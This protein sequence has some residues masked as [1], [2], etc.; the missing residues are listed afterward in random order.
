[1]R[2]LSRFTIQ[3]DDTV[4]E[5]LEKINHIPEALTLFVFD[6]KKIVGSITDGDIRRGILAG[7]ELDDTVE[8]YMHRDFSYIIHNEIDT[9]R[10]RKYK[11]K[12]I[13]LL[14]VINKDKELVRIYNLEKLES[15]LPV[16]VI[17]MAGGQGKRMRPLT[18]HLPK[19]LLKLGDKPIIEHLI[20]R[21]TKFGIETIYISVHYL[22][23]E[24]YKF[25]GNGEKWD[26]RI[27]YLAEDE[28]LGTIGS[29]T[30]AQN[31]SNP[32][33]LV[34]NSDLFTNI[35]FED[36]YTEHIIAGADLSIASIPYTVNIPYAIFEMDDRAVKSLYEKPNNTH[37]VNA[38]I[39]LMK[40]E[41][42]KYIPHNTFMNA[43]DFIHSMI[44]KRKKVIHN[45]IVGYWIDI[46]KPE[47]YQKAQEIVKHIKN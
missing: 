3:K 30:L 1:M 2:D 13:H 29:V 10:I 26:V 36:L 37:Y 23:D 32:N 27:N 9:D 25:C 43:T 34:L 18:D 6:Q 42:L 33:L 16:D 20:T 8:K 31:L 47:D 38:G 5:A 40:K 24:I 21:L 39:Y 46:G 28:P 14:P 17:I 19:P 41:L 4:L 7:N 35:D 22:A 12:G 45:P 11:K 15:I 44:T